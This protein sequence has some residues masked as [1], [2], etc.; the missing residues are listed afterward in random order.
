[1]EDSLS[2]K[3]PA[4]AKGQ[5]NPRLCDDCGQCQLHRDSPKGHPSRSLEQ[6]KRNQQYIMR[7]AIVAAISDRCE[8]DQVLCAFGVSRIIV[9]NKGLSTLSTRICIPD[10]IH[11]SGFAESGNNFLRIIHLS[12]GFHSDATADPTTTNTAQITYQLELTP[13]FSMRYGA[14]RW[15]HL[16]SMESWVMPLF[17][18]DLLKTWLTDCENLH[19]GDCA[20]NMEDQYGQY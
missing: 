20:S 3:D 12:V 5:S 1:M 7:Q 15:L 19:Q 9:K 10:D 8:G 13:Q 16:N 2:H 6:I 4:P 17:N 11:R 18:T 14:E